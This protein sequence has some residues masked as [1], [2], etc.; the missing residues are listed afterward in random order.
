MKSHKKHQDRPIQMVSP[1]QLLEVIESRVPC[2]CFLTR[3]GGKWVAVD[4]TTYDA[5]TEEFSRKRQAIRWLWGKF[6]VGEIS[7]CTPLSM[8]KMGGNKRRL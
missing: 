3:D 5:W 6:E 2:G 1:N 7:C 8:G 4:N